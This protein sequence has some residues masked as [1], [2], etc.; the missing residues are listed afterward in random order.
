ME[1]QEVTKDYVIIDGERI[2]FDE[3][4][5]EEPDKDSFE[6]WLRLVEDLLEILF[7]SRVTNEIVHTS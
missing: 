4:F 6:Q 7:C 2:Y 1:V 5:D 3:P